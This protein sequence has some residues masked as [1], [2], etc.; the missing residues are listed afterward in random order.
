MKLTRR[1]KLE[2]INSLRKG[3]IVWLAGLL[4]GEG[5]FQIFKDAQGRP[6]CMIVMGSTDLDVMQTVS[7]LWDSAITKSV[8]AGY[9][10]YYQTNIKGSSAAALASRLFPLMHS[11]R[12]QQISK[13]LQC[14]TVDDINEDEI[15]KSIKMRLVR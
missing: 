4:E 5:S 14:T 1:E 11:R 9:K 15:I 7:S 13:M 6:Y 3:D 10:D 2:R 12:Q 8:R